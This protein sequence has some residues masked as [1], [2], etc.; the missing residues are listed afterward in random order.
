MSEAGT[1]GVEEVGLSIKVNKIYRADSGWATL[2]MR[3][4]L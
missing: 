1:E 2:K 4:G 3:R